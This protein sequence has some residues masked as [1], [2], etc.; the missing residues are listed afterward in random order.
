MSKIKDLFDQ[1][2]EDYVK[3]NPQ[4]AE[5]VSLLKSIGEPIVNDHIALRTF[6]LPQVSKEEIAKPFLECGYR[7]I[8][9]YDFTEK[10]LKAS[11]YEHTDPEMPKVFISELLIEN[12]SD[13]F[14]SLV[15]KLVTSVDSEMYKNFDLM[16]SGR[17]WD[18]SFDEYQQLKQESEYG[19]WLGAIGFRPNHFTISIN[20]LKKYSDILSLNSF[21]K[22]SGYKLNG[23]GGEV[24]GSVDDLLE[25][26]STLANIVEIKFSDKTA[27]IP[28]CY[29]E[30]AK[31]YPLKSGELFQGFVA[32]SADKIFESTDKGQ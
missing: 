22:E 18:I 6:N 14:Q 30:F 32:K 9:S 12:F 8:E 17:P 4:A 20:H 5:I 13:G 25:Q 16:Y 28:S 3:L 29:F 23:Q 21:L 27:S 2:W 24:K 15:K 10:K 1:M 11:H 7:Y 26:S 19:A 31:R